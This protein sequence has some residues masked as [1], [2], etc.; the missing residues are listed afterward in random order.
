MCNFFQIFLANVKFTEKKSSE[1]EKKKKEKKKSVRIKL[2][3]II[4]TAPIYLQSIVN[5]CRI[6]LSLFVF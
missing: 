3:K 4:K 2:K 1:E 6:S 5:A